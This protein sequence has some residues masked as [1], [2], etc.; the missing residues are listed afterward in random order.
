VPL[1]NYLPRSPNASILI[2]TKDKRIGERLTNKEKAII[3]LPITEPEAERLLLSKMAQKSN[4]DETKSDE[5][6]KVLGNLS[7]AIIQAAAYIS[8]NNITVEEYLEALCSEDSEI[9]DLLS[10]DLTNL[11][12][13]FQNQNSVIQT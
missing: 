7:L 6:L 13:D 1:I 3:V 9:Q 4:L 10:E 8:E 2:T 5:L 12:R 11:R